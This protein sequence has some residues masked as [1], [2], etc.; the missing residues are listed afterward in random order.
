MKSFKVTIFIF[1]LTIILSNCDVVDDPRSNEDFDYDKYPTTIYAL[2]NLEFNSYIKEYNEL[3]DTLIC[4]SLNIFG[5][6]EYSIQSCPNRPVPREEI[7]NELEMINI[8]EATILKNKKFT[9]IES[10]E[11]LIINRSVGLSG[12]IKCDGSEDDIKTITWKIDYNNQVFDGYEVLDT[13]IIIFL[14]KNGVTRMGGNW[15]QN[16]AIPPKDKYSFEEAKNNIIGRQITLVC[17]QSYDIIIDENNI[18]PEARKVI[19]PHIK[20][21]SIELKVAWELYII[22]SNGMTVWRIYFDSTTGEMIKE[23]QLIFC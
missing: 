21:D 17:E 20:D 16:I 12:C 2:S 11:N 9:E 22:D 10:A 7:T 15:Y 1:T 13:E 23:G 6:C 3:N 4:T 14:D 5:Y 19:I 18:F 8:A